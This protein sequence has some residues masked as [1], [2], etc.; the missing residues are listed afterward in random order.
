MEPSWEQVRPAVAD[1]L[2]QEPG[3]AADLGG[4]S[5]TVVWRVRAGE[6]SY[7]VKVHRE[8]EAAGYARECSA[9]EVLT[10]TGTVPDLVAHDD[11]RRLIVM[12]DLGTGGHLADALLGAAPSLA[13][14]RLLGW[15][16]AL[17][18]LHTAATPERTAAFERA[19]VRRGATAR[20][21]LEE[22]PGTAAE[23]YAETLPGLGIDGLDDVIAA[24][25]SVP[26]RLSG[27]LVISPGDVCPD[28]NVDTGGRLQLL[29]L[30][31][32]QLLHPAWDLAYLSV[33]WP[34]CWCSW[35]LP[36][37]LADAA[38]ERY[39]QATGAGP[40]FREELALATLVWSVVSPGWLLPRALEPV[41]DLGRHADDRPEVPA[42]RA[43]VMHRLARAAA[44]TSPP[45]LEA[46]PEFAGRLHVA[47]ER[48]WGDVRLPL[49]PVWRGTTLGA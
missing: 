30:E 32:A 44:T 9:L 21:D 10:G 40:G 12:E 23:R 4:S 49:G 1:L 38:V 35:A 6:R 24:L 5:R 2:G 13:R 22:Q 18:R 33:P 16:D 25:R 14:R 45:G 27:Q 31:G 41:D 11:A 15:V 8:E 34:S 28:N 29:D 26:G 19:V 17:A 39:A 3:P 36:E 43:M 47:L 20:A 42:R 37:D 48:R 46:L 7:V